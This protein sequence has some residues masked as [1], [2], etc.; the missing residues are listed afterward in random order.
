MTPA[1]VDSECAISPQAH[2]RPGIKNRTVRVALTSWLKSYTNDALIVGS[3][4][5]KIVGAT[6]VADTDSRRDPRAIKV[7]RLLEPKQGIS[8]SARSPSMAREAER[9]RC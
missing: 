7:S 8:T 4:V 1:R 5:L 9:P 3:K 6:L 2:G